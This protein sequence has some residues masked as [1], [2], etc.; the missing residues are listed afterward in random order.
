[1]SLN[2]CFSAMYNIQQLLHKL[3]IQYSCAHRGTLEQCQSTATLELVRKDYR[4][5]MAVSPIVTIK[6]ILTASQ[7]C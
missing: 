2:E 3:N 4:S 5:Q 1:M 7:R 6:L